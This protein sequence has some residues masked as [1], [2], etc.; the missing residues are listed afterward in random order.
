ML[1]YNKNIFHTNTILKLLGLNKFQFRE[2][3]AKNR[4]PPYK[5]NHNKIILDITYNCN[6]KCIKCNRSCLYAPDD[7]FMDIL[8]VE[9]F[10]NESIKTNKFW[11]QIWIEG[12][13]PTLHPQIDAIIGV[14]L[15]YKNKYNRLVR[16]QLNSNGFST[17]TKEKLIS[18]GKK[19]KIY[20]SEKTGPHVE[21]FCSFNLAPCD[22]VEF[23]NADYSGGCYFPSF[24]GFALNMNGYYFCSNAGGID[25]VLGL[26]IGL[27]ELPKENSNWWKPQMNQLCRYCG[28]FIENNSRHLNLIIPPSEEIISESWNK[29]YESFNKQKPFLKKY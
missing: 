26:D 14:L 22:F 21:G 17:I 9:K 8:Q 3:I 5:P 2:Y 11:E 10:I 29:I 27:K 4:K 6:L 7:D 12:G 18:I 24:Y 20:S 13:E 1:V 19:I 15:E 23:E 16:I 28:H 25:R